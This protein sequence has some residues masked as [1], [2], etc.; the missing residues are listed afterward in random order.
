MRIA[1]TGHTGYI[2]AVLVPMLQ[3]L[4]HEVL[5]IDAGLFDGC[6]PL[7]P[8]AEVQELRLDLRDLRPQHLEGC[9]AVMHL[10]AVSNDPMGDLNPETTYAINHQ[11]TISTAEAAKAAGVERF[12]FSSSCSLYGAAATDRAIDEQAPFNP[13]TSYGTAKVLAERDLAALADDG[14]SPTYLRNATAYGYSPRLRTDLVVNNLTAHAVVSGEVR[15]Q[16]DGTPWRPLVHVED[17]SRAFIAL[18][19]APR[20]VV[21]DE[22]FNVGRSEENYRI[23]EVAAIVGEVV[24]GSRVTLASDAGPDKR[25]YRV[26]FD[27]LATQ[28]PTFAPQRTVRDA[29]VEIRDRLSSLALSEDELFGPRFVRLRQLQTLLGRGEIDGTLRWRVADRSEEARDTDAVH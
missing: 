25:S 24:E 26:S 21:H 10:A 22:A 16:S 15:L 3:E 12:L 4:D 8:L 29:V 2:G 23:R 11:A 5:G 13:V 19:T 7:E 27:K 18:L 1:V 9:D 20:E 28:V 14:F 17:I 6:A